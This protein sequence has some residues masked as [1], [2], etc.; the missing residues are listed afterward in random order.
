MRITSGSY[1]D[2]NFTFVNAERFPFIGGNKWVQNQIYCCIGSDF[3]L[4]FTSSNP[5]VKLLEAV[6][7]S[8]VAENPE[9][10]YPKTIEYNSSI[11]F[12][13]TEYPCEDNMI[14][15]I[16]DII[17]KKLVQAIAEHEDKTNDST[18]DSN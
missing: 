7:L 1:T 15:Q 17:I 16:T 10:A 13:D 9:D 2:I 6:K 18:D 3:R 8:Y 5:N 4:Y 12:W 14:T 11:D